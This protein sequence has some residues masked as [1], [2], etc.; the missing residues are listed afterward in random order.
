MTLKC[1][2]YL[3]K[4]LSSQFIW[5]HVTMVGLCTVW[6]VG[7]TLHVQWLVRAQSRVWNTRYE[8]KAVQ[9]Q[10]CRMHVTIECPH[11][12]HCVECSLRLVITS[13]VQC[14]ECTLR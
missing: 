8:S 12:D 11:T 7:C 13:I 2:F 6:C 10:V 4:M 14:L 5:V 1:Q 3:V 9:R